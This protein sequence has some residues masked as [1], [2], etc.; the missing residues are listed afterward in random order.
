[1]PKIFE[2]E[3]HRFF[4]FSNEGMPLKHCHIHVRKGVHIAKYWLDPEIQLEY[5]VGYASHELNEIEKQIG[6]NKEL[7]RRKWNEFFKL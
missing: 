5:S 1:M 4:F 6:K 3:G 7:I 2:W